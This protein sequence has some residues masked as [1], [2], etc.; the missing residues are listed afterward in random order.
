MTMVELKRNN[1]RF[2]DYSIIKG[3]TQFWEASWY[4]DA[5]G[6]KSF[7][8]FRKVIAK[9]V[10]TAIE[11]GIST[12]SN[13]VFDSEDKDVIQLSKF[14]CLLIAFQADTKKPMVK[15]ARRF[16]LNE[17]EELEI[18]FK[19]QNY[20]NR[21]NERRRLKESNKKLA[22]KIK[23]NSISDF[24]RF[25]NE[26]YLGMYNMSIAELKRKRKIPI[27]DTIADYM[28]ATELSANIFRI[29][30]TME[31]LKMLRRP[32]LH[33][34]LTA[35]WKVGYQIRQMVRKNTGRVPENLP[36]RANLKNSNQD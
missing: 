18:V 17:M 30:M 28:G 13:F 6:Y 32:S 22:K 20:L 34:S 26:G 35:H 23:A 25:N 5:L 4:S 29:T 8:S 21:M 15:R 9:A 24:S 3:K 19:D 1:S 11:L 33:E 7:R 2:D 14:A 12:D 16:F 10:H 31:R 36:T 27:D